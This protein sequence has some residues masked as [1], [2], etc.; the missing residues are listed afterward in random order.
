MLYNV[1]L[2]LVFVR[3]TKC[4]PTTFIQNLVGVSQYLRKNYFF[5]DLVKQLYICHQQLF[6][7]QFNV[8]EIHGKINWVLTLYCI[9]HNT[10]KKAILF[11]S[12]LY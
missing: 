5:M 2:Y 8:V 4:M 1:H 9:M 11:Y 10:R 3:D 12:K 7:L 6:K